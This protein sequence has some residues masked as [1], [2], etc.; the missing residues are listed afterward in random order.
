MT[1]FLRLSASLAAPRPSIARLLCLCMA[2]IA[3][4]WSDVAAAQT[5]SSYSDTTQ[6]SV[7]EN[8]TPCAN[9]LVRNFTVASNFLTTDVNIGVVV[10]HTYRGDLV[11]TLQS[12]SGTRVIVNSGVGNGADNFNVLLDDGAPAALSTHTSNDI[13]SSSASAPPYQHSFRPSNALSAFN[14]EAMIGTWRLEICDQYNQDSGTY[15]RSDLYLTGISGNY[16][17]L[18]L[19]KTVSNASPANGTAINYTLNVTNSSVSPQTASGVAVTDY[20]PAG[21]TF[22][23][24]S[25][26]GSYD[27]GTGIWTVG[28]IPPG[29]TR[30]LTINGTVNATAGATVTNTAEVTASSIVDVDSTPGN[31][32]ASEDDYASRSFTVAGTR[33]AGIPP[34]LSCP[35]GTSLFDWNM[36]SWA[37]GS[38]NNNYPQAN[39]GTINFAISNPATFV[40]DANFGGLSPTNASRSV[41][42]SANDGGFAS[43]ESALHLYIDFATPSQV[44]TTT[45]TLPTAVPGAQFRIFDIDYANNDFADKIIVTGYFGATP[46]YP[47]L[48]NG[49]ANYVTGNIAI[50]DAGAGNTS[51][52]GNVVVTF[53]SPIDRIV[54]GYGNHITAPSNPDGQAMAI[55]DIIFCRPTTNLTIS[56]TSSV[57][58]DPTN[59]T[60]DPKAIPGATMRYCILVSNA[61]S[62]TATIINVNDNLP[63]LASYV[64]GS[65]KSGA[66]CA[67]AT[68]PEDDN[69]SGADENDPFGASISGTALSA[70][71]PSLAPGAAFAIAFDVTVN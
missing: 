33:V 2:A 25:G 39:I 42:S 43:T 34:V 9:P 23:S 30:S 6:A 12:P 56:K 53:S 67:G 59:G 70:A 61:G 48:T 60:T 54:I 16:A 45:I 63:A 37:A 38:T 47:T 58:S 32:V 26:F 20:L 57:V 46:V 11:M 8:A 69:A 66:S 13:A 4:L 1:A 17:D 3:M 51:A 44:A 49:V 40:N 68:T 27:S 14:G 10:A 36:I 29:V 28:S 21:F 62:G 18:S 65:I 15:F 19:T 55:H 7:N 31:G 41:Y 5:S 50:G 22:V 52:D 71:A 24:A 35:A 64:A